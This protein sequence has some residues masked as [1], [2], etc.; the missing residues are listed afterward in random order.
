MA[1]CRAVVLRRDSE[2]DEAAIELALDGYASPRARV[3]DCSAASLQQVLLD[4]G[5]DT[6]AAARALGISRST[7][8][9]RLRRLGLAP[10]RRRNSGS[11]GIAAGIRP[12]S[13]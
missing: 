11:V 3:Q 4:H 2:I 12:E 1:V 13:E 5:S 10:P 8:Y 9:E 7:F 6:A